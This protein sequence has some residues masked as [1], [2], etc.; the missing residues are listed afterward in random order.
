MSQLHRHRHAK[1]EALQVTMDAQKAVQAHPSR[2][3]AVTG[4]VAEPA[5][6]E[7]LQASTQDVVSDEY[8]IVR[9]QTCV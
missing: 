7:R 2:M 1:S 6:R 8:Q 4:V 5:A 9:K 3:A